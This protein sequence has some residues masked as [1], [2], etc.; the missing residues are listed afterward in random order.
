MASPQL[1]VVSIAGNGTLG[2][3]IITHFLRILMNSD[4]F[5]RCVKTL[6]VGSKNAV[7]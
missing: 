6:E 7:R 2:K 5:L 1:S 3:Y 4:Y